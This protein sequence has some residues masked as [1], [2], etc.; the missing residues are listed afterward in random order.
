[1]AKGGHQQ[2]YLR[3]EVQEYYNYII[4]ILAGTRNNVAVIISFYRAYL[5]N[6]CSVTTSTQKLLQ[7]ARLAK[8]MK[9]QII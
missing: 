5:F 4:L 7:L 1:M 6:P 2:K 3:E 8:F 9:E